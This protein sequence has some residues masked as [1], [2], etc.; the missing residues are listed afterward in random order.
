MSTGKITSPV[1]L[2]M[3]GGL[4]C[5]AAI[6]VNLAIDPPVSWV[7]SLILLGLGGCLWALVRRKDPD[8]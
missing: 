7:I 8:V 6:L 2:A 1:V 5:L 3:A 4:S